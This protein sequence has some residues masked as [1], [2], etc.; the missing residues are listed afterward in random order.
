VLDQD[1]EKGLILWR[2]HGVGPLTFYR[3]AQAYSSFNDFFNQ[4]E[5]IWQR[6]GLKHKAIEQLKEWLSCPKKSFLQLGVDADLK[7][8]ESDDRHHI[9]GIHHQSYPSLLKQIKDPPPFLFSMGNLSLLQ[10]LQIGIVGSRQASSYGEKNAFHFARYLS[11]RGVCIVSGLAKGV[12]GQAHLG[13]LMGEGKTIGVIGHGL[14]SVYPKENKPLFDRLKEEGLIVSEFPIGVQARPEYFPRRNRII[15]GMSVGVLVVQASMKSGSL[16]TAKEAME[17]GREVFAI[18]GSIHDPTSKGCHQLIKEG[19]ALVESVDDIW[20]QLPSFASMESIEVQ[21]IPAFFTLQA[22]EHNTATLSTISPVEF[23]S[24]KEFTCSKEE[25]TIL[26][27]ITKKINCIDDLCVQT[28]WSVQHVTMLLT[29][30]ELKDY[31]LWDSLG[32]QIKNDIY[33]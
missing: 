11:D 4:P 33:Q 25:I 10:R 26:Q 28:G 16:I 14:D 22:L 30:L 3:I 13:A 32:Y 18:P 19:A 24:Q 1:L 6:F 17:Q 29:T 2:C 8:L 9:I 7:W 21:K 23:D 31:I 12:D 27:C 15:S 5:L 20:A